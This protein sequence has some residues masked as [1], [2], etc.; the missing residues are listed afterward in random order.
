MKNDTNLPDALILR[1]I[2]DELESYRYNVTLQDADFDILAEH[3]EFKNDVLKLNVIVADAEQEVLK[4][5][6]D[7]FT[8]QLL[9]VKRNVH[10]EPTLYF[11]TESDFEVC[12]IREFLDFDAKSSTFQV[13]FHKESE[14]IAADFTLESAIEHM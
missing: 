12:C 1:Q 7:F 10:A 8:H 11:L 14:H 3:T 6:T 9:V 5:S 4:I 2:K 13:K